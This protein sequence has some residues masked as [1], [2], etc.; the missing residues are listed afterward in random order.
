MP[1]PQHSTAC[2]MRG[3][4]ETCAEVIELCREVGR[5]GFPASLSD[6]GVGAQVTRAA[7][8]GAYQNVC[9]NLAELK[10]ASRKRQLLGRADAAWKR[11]I[12]AHIAAEAETLAKLRAAAGT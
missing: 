6:A 7:A 12:D 2:S 10:D 4:L 3:V 1:T 8:G 5:I 9:I 11:A